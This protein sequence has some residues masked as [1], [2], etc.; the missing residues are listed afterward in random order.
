[1]SDSVLLCIDAGTTRFKAAAI[2]P[3][4][5]GP[6][7]AMPTAC[8]TDDEIADANVDQMTLELYRFD[9]A[10]WNAYPSTVDMY[11][12]VVTATGVVTFSDWALAGDPPTAADLTSFAATPVAS[13][14]LLEWETAAEIDNLGFNLY[15]VENV[16]GESVRLNDYLIPTLV[17]G[18][19][20]G[21]QY[22]WLD[23]NVEPGASYQYWL[24]VVDVHGVTT[25]Y[26]S[27]PVMLAEASLRTIFLPLVYR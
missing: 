7:E 1:M 16:L 19:V 25:R 20:I 14:I 11:G 9:G 4:G 13:G 17:P 6:S 5:S 27:A 18:S 21:A 15:R 8:Y 12:D 24:E 3:Q 26:E 22:Q 10:S 23:Q 2:T